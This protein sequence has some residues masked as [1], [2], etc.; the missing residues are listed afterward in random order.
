MAVDRI[1]ERSEAVLQK[2]R[3]DGRQYAEKR[4]VVILQKE[5]EV[6]RLKALD[7]KKRRESLSQLKL[8][9]QG[10][11]KRT[12]HYSSSASQGSNGNSAGTPGGSTIRSLDPLVLSKYDYLPQQMMDA[13]DEDAVNIDDSNNSDEGG[14]FPP[15]PRHVHIQATDPGGA[16]RDLRNL[17]L[18]LEEGPVS[19]RPQHC[20][21]LR[22]RPH[23][24]TTTRL[25][26]FC[27]WR[28]AH[29]FT[30]AD[31]VIVSDTEQRSSDRVVRR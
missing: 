7:E 19:H 1:T 2:R 14:A 12:K 22:C 17:D 18:C 6:R 28:R 8:R 25:G 3:E 9:V 30:A 26:V 31:G 5:E 20:A 16:G 21:D 11:N 24:C 23:R 13:E 27:N 15:P 10:I 4:M 29:L